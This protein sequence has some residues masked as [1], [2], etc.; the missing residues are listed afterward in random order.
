[1]LEL[2]K[3]KVII[4][5]A[6]FGAA[7]SLILG[8]IS[9][10]SPATL[11]FHAII[12]ALL[13]GGAGL[14]LVFFL[15]Q[16]LSEEDFQSL[17]NLKLKESS[18]EDTLEKKPVKNINIL[19]ENSDDETQSYES[20]Y[21][22]ESVPKTPS[23][24]VKET[25]QDFTENALHSVPEVNDKIATSEMEMND[26]KAFKADDVETMPKVS[27]IPHEDGPALQEQNAGIQDDLGRLGEVKKEEQMKKSGINLKSGGEGVKFRVGNKNVTADPKVIADA[28]K[29]VLHRE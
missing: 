3:N 12:S 26:D 29:T 11:L 20:L 7:V 25:N 6:V 21:R 10:T 4:G 14:G 16:S 22:S 9:R 15:K 17:I 27:P 8:L 1:M 24:K 5:F 23:Y 19:D 18:G 28:I 2:I 13:L